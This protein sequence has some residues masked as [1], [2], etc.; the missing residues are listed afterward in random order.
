MALQVRISGPGVDLTRRLEAGEPALIVG[1]DSDCAFCLPDPERNVSRRHLSL[2]NEGEQLQFNVLSAVNGVQVAAGELPPGA[3]GV[4]APG[5]ELALSAFRLQVT[6]AGEPLPT[7]EQ[8]AQDPW[9]Q[10]Q[11]DAERLP[12]DAEPT[13]PAP[14]AEEDPFGDWGFHSTFGPGTPGG[15][16]RADA[17]APATDLRAFYAG[18]GFDPA[19]APALTVGE[20]EAIG[21]LTRIAV[22]GLLQVAEA[23]ARTRQEA[24]ADNTTAPRRELN[25]L[26]MD[27]PL[28]TKLSYLFGG[29]PAAVGFMPAA[30]A[31]AQVAADLGAHERAMAQ[32]VQE[33]LQ[34]VLA[35]FDPE[36]L[37]KRL[38]GGGGRLFE[39]ARAWDAFAR[40][41]AERSGAQPAWVQQLLDRHFARA[42]ARALLRAKRN[43]VAGPDG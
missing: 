33:A 26:R 38:L 10:L 21:Q 4:L 35:D 39:S 41:Y 15:T 1:R 5:E 43:T 32:A 24:R 2:W 34:G 6:Q 40:D 16:L 42:Y 19:A 31:V 7:G 13:A 36:A 37:K 27:A 23:A 3:R 28:P 17:L 20:L 22:Q 14:K 11:R 29:A 12:R 9:V 30:D 18:L 25:P 8:D